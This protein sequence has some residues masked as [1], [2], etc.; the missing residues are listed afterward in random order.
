EKIKEAYSMKADLED[1][2]HIHDIERYIV[3]RSL[4]RHWQDHLTEMEEL[5]R[6]VGLRG[7]GQKDPLSEYK[8][9]GFRYFQEMMNRARTDMCTGV[10][11]TTTNPLSL[12]GLMDRLKNLAN[13]QG[14]SEAGGAGLPQQMAA[15]QTAMASQAQKRPEQRAATPRKELPKIE[16]IRREAPKVGRNETVVIRKG[17][18]SRELKFKKAEQLIT[19][20]GWVL[21]GTKK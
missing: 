21:V 7:Y 16:P 8:S 20:E 4:D 6:A 12:Q 17:A 10:F 1:P 9:E 13:Q 14:P 5:R 19:N 11:R 15:A 18:E 2:E 3:V